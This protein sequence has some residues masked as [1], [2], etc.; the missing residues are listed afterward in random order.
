MKLTGG[1]NTEQE[2]VT[3]VLYSLMVL[4]SWKLKPDKLVLE[5][6]SFFHFFPIPLHCNV[7]SEL[8]ELTSWEVVTLFLCFPL[9]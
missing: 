8:L 3:K 7:G 5:L 2:L 9:F 4:S 6:A 1:K